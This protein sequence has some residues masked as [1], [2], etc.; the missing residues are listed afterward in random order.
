MKNLTSENRKLGD[1]SEYLTRIQMEVQ[2]NLSFG[3]PPFMGHKHD[4]VPEKCSHNL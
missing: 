2:R 1:N 4:L 3:T